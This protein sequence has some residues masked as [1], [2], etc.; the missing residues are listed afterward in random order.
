MIII[1]VSV[2]ISAV[3]Y[4]TRVTFKFTSTSAHPGAP[5]TYFNDGGGGGV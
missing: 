1:A 5:L 2:A 4:A 3:F